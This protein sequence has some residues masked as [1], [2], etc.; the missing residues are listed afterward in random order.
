MPDPVI[1]VKALLTI[2]KTVLEGNAE[3]QFRVGL[4]KAALKAETAP[5]LEVVHQL[6]AALLSEVEVLAR[7]QTLKPRPQTS[8]AAVSAGENP[9][10]GPKAAATGGGKGASKGEGQPPKS[11]DPAIP[12][13]QGACRFYV[14]GIGCNRVISAVMPITGRTSRQGRRSLDAC[15]V[16]VWAIKGQPALMLRPRRSRLHRHH[17]A[18]RRNPKGW[19]SQRQQR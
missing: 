11:Q 1:L 12:V 16:E 17:H 8:A 10:P 15:P 2:V 19:R 6:H 5:S 7:T 9:H 14:Q 13:P 4:V 18:S 3:V